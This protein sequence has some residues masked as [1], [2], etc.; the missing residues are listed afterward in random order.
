MLLRDR[1]TERLRVDP[2]LE[3]VKTTSAA[4]T[5]D[6]AAR[7]ADDRIAGTTAAEMLDIS[8]PTLM[9]LVKDGVLPAYKVGSHTRLHAKDVITYRDR[10]RREQLAALSEL[11][12]FEDDL[13]RTY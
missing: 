2:T 5:A 10:V 6:A 7:G 12:T 3:H 4:Q 1:P 9:K 8:R 11:R 13:G